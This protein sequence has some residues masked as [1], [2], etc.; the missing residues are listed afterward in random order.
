MAQ[1]TIERHTGRQIVESIDIAAPAERVFR[2]L[3]DPEALMAWWGDP[4][5]YPATH[6]EIELRKG[7]KWLSRWK[8]LADG[9]EFELGGEVLE[10]RAP[11][12]LVV[13]WWDDRYPGLEHTTVRY[14]IERL[15]NGGSRVRVTHSGFD[16]T[17]A[18]FDDYNGGW[19]SVLSSLRTHAETVDAAEPHVRFT[20]NHDIA[21]DVADLAPAE[22]FYAGTLGFH[23]RS[24]GEHHL[25]IDTGAFTLWVNCTGGPSRSFIPSLD[26]RDAA[27]A[28]AMLEAAG[29]RVV[30]ESAEGNG[31]YFEDPFGFVIDVVERRT[32]PDR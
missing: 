7:G 3:T 13:S 32:V 23:I 26:V 27:A 9:S 18:D 4:T 29:C 17:R 11:H 24:R 5:S 10:V 25:E 21:I 19:S 14:E 16:G 31:F 28:R 2:A 8:N 12:L 30:R 15:P 6:W 22:A 1:Q 20:S